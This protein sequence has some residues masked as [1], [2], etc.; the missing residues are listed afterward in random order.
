M[1]KFLENLKHQAEEN[2]V[3]ALAAAGALATGLSKL[4]NSLAWKQEVK[5]RAKKDTKK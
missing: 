4:V 1:D 3:V 5:R 2:P